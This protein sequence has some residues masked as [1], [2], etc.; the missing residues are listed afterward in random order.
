MPKAKSQKQQCDLTASPRKRS[1]A[2][3]QT[4][5]IAPNFPPGVSR[6]ALRALAGVGITKLEQLEKFKAADLAK[7]HGMGPKAMGLLKSGLKAKGKS[8]AN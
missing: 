2:N 8:F 6:P 5:T 7:L 1:A 3:K 4:D